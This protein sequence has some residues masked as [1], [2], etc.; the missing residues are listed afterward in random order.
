[1]CHIKG[2]GCSFDP[3]RPS[4]QMTRR[5]SPPARPRCT[6]PASAPGKSQLVLLYQH[7]GIPG[8]SDAALA[9]GTMRDAML[10]IGFFLVSS[11][12]DIAARD[13]LLGWSTQLG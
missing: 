6:S 10:V 4:R 5:L 3:P 7:V 11:H 13:E 8:S 9:V 12:P 2:V 1:M